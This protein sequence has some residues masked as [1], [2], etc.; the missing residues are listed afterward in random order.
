MVIKEQT[1]VVHP[2][3]TPLPDLQGIKG[4]QQVV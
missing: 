2:A 4:R 1:T 3:P